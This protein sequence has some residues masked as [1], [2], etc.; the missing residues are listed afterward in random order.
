MYVERG[1]RDKTN[2]IQDEQATMASHLPYAP[3]LKYVIEIS[4][5]NGSPQLIIS[6]F[7]RKPPTHYFHLQTEEVFEQCAAM[8]LPILSRTPAYDYR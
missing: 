3:T 1:G 2:G 5:F 8:I 7:K 6:T 4:T